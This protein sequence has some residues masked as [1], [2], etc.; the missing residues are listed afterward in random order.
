MYIYEYIYVHTYIHIYTYTYEYIYTGLLGCEQD[1]HGNPH[2]VIIIIRF[3]N[4]FK[5][6]MMTKNDC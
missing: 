3:Y 2:Q 1:P 4:K 6:A 5:K